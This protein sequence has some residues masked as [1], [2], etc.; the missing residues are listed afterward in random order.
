MQHRLLARGV[1]LEHGSEAPASNESCAI[2][3][4]GIALRPSFP[5]FSPVERT[6]TEADLLQLQHEFPRI[7][8]H[9]PVHKI[10]CKRLHVHR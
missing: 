7:V 6:L 9:D 8:S 3:I 5:D 10:G 1:H 4:T 2:Q